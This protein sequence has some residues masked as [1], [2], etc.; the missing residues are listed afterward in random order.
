[1]HSK[2][3]RNDRHISQPHSPGLRLSYLFKK[4]RKLKLRKLDWFGQRRELEANLGIQLWPIKP[5]AVIYVFHCPR[6]G[7]HGRLEMPPDG[8]RGWSWVSRECFLG[9]LLAA[10][11]SSVG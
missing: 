6:R 11:F 9:R 3:C 10:V 4:M 7:G 5:Y 2:H 1:M 8:G